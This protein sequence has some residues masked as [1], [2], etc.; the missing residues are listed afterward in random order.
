[1]LCSSAGAHALAH[2]LGWHGGVSTFKG[3]GKNATT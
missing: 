2:A 3:G 1:M